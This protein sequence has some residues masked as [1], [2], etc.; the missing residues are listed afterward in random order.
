M[1]RKF[2]LKFQSIKVKLT[3]ILLL[4]CLVPIILSQVYTYNKT[5]KLLDKEFQVSTE[6]TLNEVN[7]GI[8]NYLLGFEGILN[9]M[10]ENDVFKNMNN[11]EED[12]KIALGLLGNVVKSRGDIMQAYFG[13]PDKSFTIY[14]ESKM[15]D[16]FDPTVR[17]WYKN[18]MNKKG[19][20]T[21]ADPY[22]SAV[23]GKTI[24]SISR[25]VENNGNVVGV[26]SMN[27]NLEVLSKDIANIK[28]G[29]KGYVFLTDSKGL[30]IAHPDS[31]Q[32]GGDTITT[33][34]YWERAKVEKKGFEKYIYNEEEK[35]AVYTTNER[36]GWKLMGSLLIDE[37]V[38]KTDV[39]KKSN[40]SIL[41]VIGIVGV[42]IA[43]L[44][45]KSITSK[46]IVIKNEF[47]KASDGNLR[48]EVKINSKDE[49]GELGENFN[50]MMRNIR[51]LI[52]SVNASSE[53]I[54]KTS[55]DVNRMAGETNVA[56]NEVAVTID[57]VAQGASET[58]KDIQI[59][60]EA[61][62]N[63]ATKID[64]IDNLTNEMIAI[65]D[66]SN[67]LSQEGLRVMNI[68]TDKTEKNIKSSSSVALVVSD[69][70]TETG[71]IS[72]I[73]DTIN[74]ISAQTNLLALNAAIEAARAGEAGRG[75]SVVADEIRKLAEQST[76]A[77]KQIQ[78]LIMGVKNKTESA[79]QSI[80]TSNSIVEEQSQAVSETKDIFNK[81]L[82]AINDLMNEI[83]LV[84]NAA[85]ETNK[86]KEE[87]VGR[88]QNISAVSEEASASAEEVS[89]TTEEV[90]AAMNE[91]TNSAAGLKEL[92]EKLE[93]QIKKFKI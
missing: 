28:I 63:L 23:D 27:V 88:M 13:Q 7:K 54:T 81:I 79:V 82:E 57:Q 11:S 12:K 25:T 65:S 16:G 50:I 43:L 51:D 45:S 29:Q 20:V 53:I 5:S 49:F 72:V 61:V 83:K 74:Q 84:Q 62:N 17:P 91:F 90:S 68:L 3:A 46:I 40:L 9:S 55:S 21:Y 8:D 67:S 52:L 32:I 41:F 69:M 18:A 26:I 89:A 48:A 58:A 93:E 59:S 85:T 39:I 76:S 77:T 36:T 24:I 2:N 56:L 60:V 22:K 73:T 86:A 78:E 35:Y 1:N 37:L 15:E 33:L 75:F 10:A 14:P 87:L 19:K 6:L 92:S 66:K 4:L 71:K 34:S 80:E 42:V 47:D 38:S 64:T 70:K 30:M 44:V 31:K